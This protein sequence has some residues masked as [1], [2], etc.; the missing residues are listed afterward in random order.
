VIDVFL[1][2]DHAL[3]RDGCRRILEAEGDLR[4]VGEATNAATVLAR[5]A[6]ETWDVLVLDL[7]LPDLSGQ[8]VL[9]QLREL[10]P[11][12]PV[13]MMSMYP[14]E[15]FAARL[16]QAGARGYL[17]K[18]RTA[19]DLVTAVR[20]VHAGRT[21]LHPDVALA[22]VNEPAPVEALSARELE[23]LRML[24]GGRTSSQIAVA[25]GLSASTVSTHLHRIK[26]R[27]G[28]RSLAELVQF[29]IRS[30]IRA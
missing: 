22:L 12:L 23:V 24:V 27:V 11:R 19:S 13:V 8:E 7:E 6:R 20:Q 18:E 9:R 28:A 4:V 16:L 5:A 29:A 26:A 21:Y 3:V 30:G 1:T 10:R 14:E 25:L 15:L 17:S 2:D